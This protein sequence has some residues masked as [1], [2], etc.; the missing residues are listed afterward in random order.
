MPSSLAAL[1]QATCP[2][3]ANAESRHQHAPDRGI[4]DVPLEK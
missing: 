3:Q 2:G 1:D 4:M